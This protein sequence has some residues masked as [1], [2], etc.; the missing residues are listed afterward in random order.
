[1]DAG[2]DRT[3]LMDKAAF[4]NFVAEIVPLLDWR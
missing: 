1:M 2:Y 4:L 3:K